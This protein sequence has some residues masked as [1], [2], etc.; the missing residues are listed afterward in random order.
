MLFFV[1]FNL[2]VAAYALSRVRKTQWWRCSTG[3][4]LWR[5]RWEQYPSRNPNSPFYYSHSHMKAWCDDCGQRM[6]LTLTGGGLASPFG[7]GWAPDFDPTD[8][9]HVR[10]MGR[11][12]GEAD[13]N[14]PRYEVRDGRGAF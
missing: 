3:R 14:N 8:P 4:H 12:W 2:L 13:A 5:A 7:G 10:D 9:K 1:V 6:C 11:P